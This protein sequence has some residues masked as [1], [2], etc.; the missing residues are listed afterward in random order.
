MDFSSRVRKNVNVWVEGSLGLSKL[1]SAKPE[2]EA[3]IRCKDMCKH[4]GLKK[5]MYTVRCTQ[6]V[7]RW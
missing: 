3:N 2:K 1:R 4:S 7:N 5:Q 6:T